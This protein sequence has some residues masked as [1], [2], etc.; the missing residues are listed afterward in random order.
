MEKLV[1]P[2]IPAQYTEL[3]SSMPATGTLKKYFK[4]TTGTLSQ[5]NLLVSSP[6]LLLSFLHRCE[7]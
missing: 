1:T 3:G 6:S 5:M 7:G 4:S 2:L